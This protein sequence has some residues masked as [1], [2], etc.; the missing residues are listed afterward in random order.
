MELIDTQEASKLLGITQRTVS[1]WL[2]Q[3]KLPGIK[4]GQGRKAEWR[5]NRQDLLEYLRKQ[6]NQLQRQIEEERWKRHLEIMENAPESD[7]PLTPEEERKLD[8]AEKDIAEGKTIPW[9]QV[10]EELGL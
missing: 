8:E 6:S 3:N 1:V 9:E 5:L 4:I 2:K 10:K 7:E